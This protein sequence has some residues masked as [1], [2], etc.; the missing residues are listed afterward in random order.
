LA[1]ANQHIAVAAGFDYDL[2]SPIAGSYAGGS[3]S[4]IN[5]QLR[6]AADSSGL[7]AD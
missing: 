6:V 1:V 3:Q 2:A 5:A 7:I 4:K